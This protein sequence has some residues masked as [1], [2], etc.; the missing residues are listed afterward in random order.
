MGR[1]AMMMKRWMT[2]GSLLLAVFVCQVA[3]SAEDTGAGAQQADKKEDAPGAPA[4]PSPGSEPPAAAKQTDRKSDKKG[5][6]NK[7]K[8][9][10]AAK[11]Q[12]SSDSEPAPTFGTEVEVVTVDVV[13]ASKKGQPVAG[14][15]REDFLLTEDDQPQT[16]SSFEAIE[17]PETVSAEAR[18]QRQVSTNV[19]AELRTARTF[20]VVFDDMNLTHVQGLRAKEAIRAFLKKGIREGDRVLLT[21]SSGSA[22]WSAR[23][24]S[25]RDELLAIL[26]RVDGRRFADLSPRE[27]ILDYEALRIVEF[28]DS[29]VCQR[30]GRRFEE[31]GLSMQRSDSQ[32]GQSSQSSQGYDRCDPLVMSRAQDVYYETMSRTRVT[33][34]T[35]KRVFEALGTT[36]G[37]KALILVSEGFVYNPAIDMFREAVQASRRANVAVYFVD[38]RGLDFGDPFF[39]A[40]SNL[41]IFAQDLGSMHADEQRASEGAESIAADTGGFSVKN[42]NDLG[43]GIARIADESRAYYLLG[44]NPANAARDG[45]FRKIEVKVNRKGVVVRAR[46]GYYAPGR[47]Q[48]VPEEKDGE[49]P[50]DLRR[51]IDAPFEIDGIALRMASYVLDETL[52]G[53]ARV[54]VSAEVDIRK[55]AFEQVADRFTDT[56]DVYLVVIHRESGET[57]QYP[58]TVVMKLKPSTR[59]KASWYPIAKDFDL[60]SGHYQAKLVV[61]DHNSGHVGSVFHH[62]DVP[63][64]AGLRISTPI[65]SDTLLP[66]AEPSERPAPQVLARRDFPVNQTLYCQFQVFGATKDQ[67]AGMPSVLQ[68]YSVVSKDG[69]VVKRMQPSRIRATDKGELMRLFGFPL[70]DL[71]Q[72][73]FE[74]I[75]EFKDELSGKTKELREAF[76]VI[77]ASDS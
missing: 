66:K 30:V 1:K 43:Q 64:L 31:A 54:V 2:I 68:G 21:S 11:G 61:R 10:S 34:D 69:T 35:L 29:E 18:P 4:Q 58:E 6:K 26:E 42:T 32:D 75:M 37:R 67:D 8:D 14:L 33:L 74:L 40:E 9:A 59:E 71:G 72:G 45:K 53:R 44:Y 49:L 48:P 65:L 13:V 76:R 70:S 55:L 62:F 16:I 24:E 27:R 39:S 17:L 41:T 73:E 28:N 22:W 36:R 15:R 7:E 52:L 77:Q 47:G 5:K 60:A 38:T 51:A 3:P 23:M 63:D 19:E 20:A 25:G 12:S 56:L 46:R 50:P 57:F